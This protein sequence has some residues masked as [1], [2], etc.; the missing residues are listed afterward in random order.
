MPR[1]EFL[2]T[3]DGA[4]SVVLLPGW[5]TD[6]RVFAGLFPR[7]TA[8]T[9]GPLRPEGFSR[10]LAAF[11]DRSGARAP[12]TL[13]G[14][15]LGGFLAAEFA[16]DYPER[17]GR[18][19]LVGIRRAYPA[20]DV[21]AVREEVLRHRAAC[22]SGFYAQCFFPTQTDSFR[23]FRAGLQKEYIREMDE[24]T[25]LSGLSYLSGARLSGDLLPRC[26]VAL[27]HGEKDVVAPAA[28]AE[29]VARESGRAAFH[30]I[31]GAAHAAFLSEGF[32][33]VAADA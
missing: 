16:R 5:A 12:V 8:A 7:A 28:E 29:S 26:P 18:A 24:T 3:G 32:K 33:T 10:R 4:P 14:W 30:R 19:I 1:E 11:L 23:R 9:T 2:V 20:G 15:S 6:G 27:V 21:E 31:P 22:L 13:V 25:L 17:I